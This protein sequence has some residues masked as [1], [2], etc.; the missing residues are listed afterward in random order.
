MSSISQMERSSS[1]TRMLATQPPF[2]GSRRELR[3]RG[4]VFGRTGADRV[5]FCGEPFCGNPFCLEPA[6]PQ[7]E[8]R[9]LPGLGAGP[10][11]T[12]VRLYDLVDHGQA[13]S[14]AAF[15]VRLEGLE[16]LLGL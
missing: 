1:Q 11:F 2:P 3:G 16:N 8:G 12:F 7:D 9:P 6:Q 5:P 15:K 13:K 10:H 14:R 4:E